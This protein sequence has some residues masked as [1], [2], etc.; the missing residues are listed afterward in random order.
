VDFGTYAKARQVMLLP[1][2]SCLP[3][4]EIKSDPAKLDAFQAGLRRRHDDNAKAL[5]FE[6]DET[7]GRFVLDL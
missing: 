1:A 3:S 7:L 2:D 4:D 5:G 6:Y